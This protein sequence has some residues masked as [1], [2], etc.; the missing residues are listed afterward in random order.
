MIKTIQASE[1]RS[2]FKSALGHVKMTKE[3]LIITERGIP[4]SVLVSIDEY[5]DYLN[6]R[7]PKFVASIKAARKEHKEGKT[8]SFQD[9]FGNIE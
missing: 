9:V 3:P 8:Y 1:L 7:D 6:A 5:E 2:G 4:T